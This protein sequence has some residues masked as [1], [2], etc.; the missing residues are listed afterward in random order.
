MNT[1][2]KIKK[3]KTNE[4]YSKRYL[5]MRIISDSLYKHVFGSICVDNEEC[6]WTRV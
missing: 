3:A 2:E 5:S 4:L 6:N 1:I